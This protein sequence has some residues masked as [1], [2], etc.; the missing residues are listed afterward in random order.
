MPSISHNDLWDRVIDNLEQMHPQYLAELLR[1]GELEKVVR[2][3]AHTFMVAL[4]QVQR[5]YPNENPA[6]HDEIV[7]HAVW[8]V[9][10]N[11][12]C[13]APLTA[14]EEKLLQAFQE[15]HQIEP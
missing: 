3:Q 6:V 1:N 9:N 7:N 4:C 8:E 15:K 2:S 14:E 5:S 11:R 12:E 10:P 13:Q